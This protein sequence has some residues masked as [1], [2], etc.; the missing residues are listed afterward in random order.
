MSLL[1][2][3]EDRRNAKLVWKMSL[4]LGRIAPPV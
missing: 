2:E 1:A 4:L 3:R